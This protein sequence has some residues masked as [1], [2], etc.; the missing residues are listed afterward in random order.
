MLCGLQNIVSLQIIG[1]KSNVFSPKVET[2][3]MWC[4]EVFIMQNILHRFGGGKR[5]Y[6]VD[7]FQ[8]AFLMHT[9]CP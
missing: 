9:M 7:D 6:G 1:I 2:V 8:N 5:D 3:C 4:K